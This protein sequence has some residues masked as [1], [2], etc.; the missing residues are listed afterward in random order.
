M[1][2]DTLLPCESC[3]SKRWYTLFPFSS[4][5]HL[6]QSI[7]RTMFIALKYLLYHHGTI[8]L[9]DEPCPK[10]IKERPLRQAPK[11]IRYTSTHTII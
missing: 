9:L 4:V 10:S 8:H 7:S 3:E 11:G 5:N 6:Y 1:H 2:T